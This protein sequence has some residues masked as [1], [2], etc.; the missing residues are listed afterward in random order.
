MTDNKSKKA[1]DSKR[2]SL[3]ESYEATRWAKVLGVTPQKLTAAV[4]KVGSS[5]AKVKQYIKDTK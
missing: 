4:G 3:G 1:L 2:I 5:V